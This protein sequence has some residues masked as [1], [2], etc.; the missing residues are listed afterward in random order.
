[1]STPE[2]LQTEIKAYLELFGSNSPR[3]SHLTRSIFDIRFIDS[4]TTL[5]EQ[6]NTLPLLTAN[7]LR[8]TL[9]NRKDATKGWKTCLDFIKGV[10][11]VVQA[12]P[13]HYARNEVNKTRNS[14]HYDDNRQNATAMLFYGT[15]DGYEALGPAA[16]YGLLWAYERNQYQNIDLTHKIVGSYAVRN[17]FGIG[18]QGDL[19]TSEIVHPAL[20][21]NSSVDAVLVSYDLQVDKT[22]HRCLAKSLLLR[23]SNNDN[24]SVELCEHPELEDKLHDVGDIPNSI[25]D[26]NTIGE[27]RLSANGL[28]VVEG[29]PRIQTVI[30]KLKHSRTLR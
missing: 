8:P 5:T 9:G 20:V 16:G 12:D 18:M 14:F 15:G 23:R 17:T 1:M 30:E 11:P 10:M 2:K 24:N 4:V 25:N 27:L 6:D 28:V 7:A 29:S 26:Y 22:A 13:E 19:G 21:L 3:Y